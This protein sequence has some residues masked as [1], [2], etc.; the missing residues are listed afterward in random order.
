MRYLTDRKRAVGSGSGSEGTHH[1]WKMMVSSI[2]LAVIAPF[3]IFTFGAGLGSSYEEAQAFLSRPFVVLVLALG[4]IVGLNHF[5]ME[6]DEA[7][8]DYVH[9]I[10]GKLTLIAVSA[11]TYLLMAVGLFALLKLAI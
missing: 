2:C 11:V 6:I 4:L 5:R 10:A 8:E 9:G 1:H 3:F 7:V